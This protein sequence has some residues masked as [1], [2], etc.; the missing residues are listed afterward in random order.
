MNSK[1]D[2]VMYFYWAPAQVIHKYLSLH[3]KLQSFCNV[4]TIIGEGEFGITKEQFEHFGPI[5][6]K[7]VVLAPTKRA[8]S[9]LNDNDYKIGVFSSNGRK[10]FVNPDGSEPVPLGSRFPGLGKDIAIA[11]SKGAKTIQISEMITDFYYAGADIASLVSPA[12]RDIHMN[13]RRFGTHHGYQWR[14]FDARPEP[15]YIYSNCLLWEKTDDCLPK[16]SKSE[17]CKKYNLKE[18]KD[19]FVYLPSK[20][21]HVMN[22]IAKKVYNKICSMDNVVVKFHPTEYVRLASGRVDNKWSTELCGVENVSVLDPLDTHWCYEYSSCGLTN[23]SSVSIELPLY[24][25]PFLYVEP[26]NFALSS[27]FLRF[28][29]KCSLN[30]VENYLTEKKYQNKIENLDEFYGTILTDRDKKASDI[31]AAQIKELLK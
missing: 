29:N 9:I 3:K 4:L 1:Y 7:N 5:H 28:G 20:P 8:L 2:V 15:E 25:T 6:R 21:Q 24:D 13:P 19:I 23:Q 27:F 11:K 16:M 18:D 10:G 22:G 17:F 31:L 26:P 14:P 12:M 30:E